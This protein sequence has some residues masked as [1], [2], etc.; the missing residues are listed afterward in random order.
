[1]NIFIFFLNQNPIFFSQTHSAYSQTAVVYYDPVV[2]GNL[3][4][5]TR[6]I[7]SFLNVIDRQFNAG[8]FSE[9]HA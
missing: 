4:A 8:A 3:A 6:P 1:L 7:S 9:N 2:V 5:G